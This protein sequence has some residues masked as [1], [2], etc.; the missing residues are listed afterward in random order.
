MKN[1]KF[2]LGGALVLATLLISSVP[3]KASA[4]WNGRNS[5]QR[6]NSAMT[7]HRDNFQNN[8]AANRIYTNYSVAPVVSYN[9]YPVNVYTPNIYTPGY[10]NY[11]TNYS[12][13]VYPS[14]IYL[15]D[16]GNSNAVLTIQNS[17]FN[18]YQNNYA[19]ITVDHNTF[20][21]IASGYNSSSMS[22]SVDIGNNIVTFNTINGTV[23]A[24]NASIVLQ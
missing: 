18:S 5:F 13:F 15:Y 23:T 20:V 19:R 6:N 17:M 7:F 9:P 2:I 11:G 12:N 8:F 16:R 21:Q 22:V 1:I 4:A 10:V 14:T 24:I 3:A